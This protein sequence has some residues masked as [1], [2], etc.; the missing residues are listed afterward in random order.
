MPSKYTQLISSIG[1]KTIAPMN[2]TAEFKIY[3]HSFMRLLNKL[4]VMTLTY[5]D[6]IQ[7]SFAPICQQN[8]KAV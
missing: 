2:S 8:Y 7:L 5:I 6:Q 1:S 4:K 3:V